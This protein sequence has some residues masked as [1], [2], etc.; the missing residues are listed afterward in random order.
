VAAI[1]IRTCDDWGRPAD[2]QLDAGFTRP[3]WSPPLTRLGTLHY[4]WND[5]PNPS[6]STMTV[7][8]VD[9]AL[10]LIEVLADHPEGV[11]LVSLAGGLGLAKSATHRLL[12]SLAARGY[13]TQ[14]EATQRYRLSMKLGT[15]GFRI[16]DSRCLPDLAQGVL[17]RLAGLVGEYCRIAVVE[18]RMLHW[19]ARAQG[20]NRGLRYDPPMGAEVALHATASGKAWLATLP[21]DEAIEIAMRR[22]LRRRQGMGRRTLVDVDELRRQLRET[23]RRGYAKAVDEAEAGVLALAAAFCTSP[24]AGAAAAGTV[25]IAGPALRLTAKRAESL[26]PQL[27]IA[28]RE[29]TNAW[30]VWRRQTIRG[31]LRD[32][33]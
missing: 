33:A 28:A 21:E 10:D 20:A 14:D 4:I 19:A 26:V 9:R 6:D 1:D 29:M 7:A 15:L 22:G 5:V 13:V 3:S 23:R 25:S 2:G 8:N 31:G 27:L 32:A 12:Q 30:P 24:A 18:S 17:D 11:A 16:I